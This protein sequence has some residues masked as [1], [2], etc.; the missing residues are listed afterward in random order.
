MDRT[1]APGYIDIGGGRR[2]FRD[3]NTVAGIAGTGI[4]AADM[5]A[6]QEELL[7]LVEGVG[8]TPNAA[9]TAQVW[10]AV[11]RMAGRQIAS[12]T[13]NATLTADHGIVF[14]SAAGGSLTLTLPLASALGGNVQGAGTVQ[15]QQLTFIRTDT[16]ANTV[17][18]QRQGANTLGTGGSVNYLLGVSERLRIISDGNAAW[19][20]AS[21]NLTG[22][23]RHVMTS[24]GNFTV[25]AW[26][27][28]I[29]AKVVAGGGGGAGCP[30]A[31]SAGGGGAG[32]TA[33]GDLVVTP[34]AV[35]AGV[36]GAAGAGGAAGNNNGAAGGSSSFSTLSATGGGGG[37]SS[38][39]GSS[40]GGGGG[41][42]S[43]GL[44]NISGGMGHDGVPSSVAGSG[45]V[46]TEGG[47][48]R[49]AS[50]GG[51]VANGRAPGSG[52]GGAYGASAAAGGDGA[53]GY[54]AI[55]D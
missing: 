49:G 42:A 13:G 44:E 35:M 9:A 2:G 43:G 4:S 10:Q 47:G 21:C 5:N 20:L 50:G 1:I 32:G 27:E 46:S 28:R 34:G 31:G 24:S 33:D 38:G 45:G 53:A 18:L 8:L 48:G 6:Q 17:T 26:V 15:A 36:V 22:R 55:W 41:T 52:G 30:A 7:A 23:R 3:R 29:R 12:F 54:I 37:L 39:G 25:P 51:I 14:V 40:S 19:H 11:H 16:S